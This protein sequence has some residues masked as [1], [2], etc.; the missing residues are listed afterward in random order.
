VLADLAQ[1][2]VGLGKLSTAG[3]WASRGLRQYK[4][5]E[6]TD[7]AARMTFA[8][9]KARI[10]ETA[11][12]DFEGRL[13]KWNGS[14]TRPDLEFVAREGTSDV[15]SLRDQAQ[16]MIDPGAEQLLVPVETAPALRPANLMFTRRGNTLRVYD[17]SKGE[18]I[19]DRATLPRAAETVLLGVSGDTAVLMQSDQLIGLNLKTRQTWNPI[20]LRA[21][22]GVVRTPTVTT[23]IRSGAVTVRVNDATDI[24]EAGALIIIN[25]NAYTADSVTLVDQ[26][27]NPRP[28]R[29]ANDPETLRRAAFAPLGNSVRFSTAMLANGKVYLLAGNQLDAYD[30][31]TGKPAWIGR[32]GAK[33][34]RILPE[35][36]P[37]CFVA[38][39]DLVV[40]Q[41]DSPDGKSSTFATFDGETGQPGRQFKL[42][43]ER[44]LWR[45]LGED[46]T[47]YVV[48]NQAVAAYDV[49]SEAGRANW[50][51]TDIGAKYAGGTALTLDGLI[52]VSSEGQVQS[53]ALENG[54]RRWS[55]SLPSELSPRSTAASTIRSVVQGDL[56]VFQ[57]AEGCAA[58]HSVSQDDP[59][60]QVAWVVKTYSNDPLPPRQSMQFFDSLVVE[61]FGGQVRT[62]ARTSALG[63]RYVKG[64]KIAFNRFFAEGDILRN[65]QALDNGIAVDAGPNRIYFIRNKAP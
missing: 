46:G 4:D 22:P 56:V 64:G 5:F 21:A 39:E 10:S 43:N 45:A 54:E 49:M 44:A 16:S 15:I 35:G 25:G 29:L 20:E 37:V 8:A 19:V 62:A 31:A 27:G 36:S 53:L 12:A 9:L 18:F 55:S 30:A 38:N 42:E 63:A 50:R 26:N 41:V 40:A 59:S 28:L 2:N 23:P 51:K 57:S 33:L 17:T 14:T 11:G 3:A 1:V 7:G 34:T 24:Q 32:D 52:V 6:W 48:S 65:W 13:P 61:Q 58:F 60:R 47:L